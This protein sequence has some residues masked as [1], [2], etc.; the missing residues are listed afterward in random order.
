MN[1]PFLT[2]QKLWFHPTGRRSASSAVQL[3]AIFHAQIGFRRSIRVNPLSFQ[4]AQYFFISIKF[5]LPGRDLRQRETLTT[6]N[7]ET[8]EVA[9]QSVFRHPES[10]LS[11]VEKCRNRRAC[12]S[13][14]Q[15]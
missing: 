1:H 15:A 4:S 13:P 14:S 11:C 12:A 8:T 3:A 10:I 5:N 6:Q 7:A 2:A 9:A